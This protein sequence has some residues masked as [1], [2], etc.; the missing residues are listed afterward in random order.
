MEEKF[1]AMKSIAKESMTNMMSKE[2]NQLKG[3]RTPFPYF[4]HFKFTALDKQSVSVLTAVHRLALLRVLFILEPEFLKSRDH[5]WIV[6]VPNHVSLQNAQDM[7][8]VH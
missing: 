7:V 6:V 5:V 3:E 2:T 1:E 8:E 4:P